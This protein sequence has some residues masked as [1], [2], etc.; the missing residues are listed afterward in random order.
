[1]Y[2]TKNKFDG[3]FDSKHLNVADVQVFDTLEVTRVYSLY[4]LSVEPIS[5]PFYTVRYSTTPYACTGNVSYWQLEFVVIC[6]W[7]QV[8]NRPRFR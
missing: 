8:S 5:N 6:R 7:S 1:M 4:E 2:S 3:H